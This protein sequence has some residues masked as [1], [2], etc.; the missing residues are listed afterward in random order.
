MRP[1]SAANSLVILP[2][3]PGAITWDGSTLVFTPNLPWPS[4]AEITVQFEGGAR[5]A[6][7]PG[8][9]LMQTFTWRFQ[10]SQ[11]TLA[12]LWPSAG[13]ADLYTL[14]PSS[15]YTRRLTNLGGV[16]GYSLSPDGSTFF[17]S[18]DDGSGV[19]WIYRLERAQIDLASEE[20]PVLTPLIECPRATCYRAQLSPDGQWLVYER[21]PLSVSGTSAANAVWL[22]SMSEKSSRLL[23][24][25]GQV[26]HSPV[27]SAASMLAYYSTRDQAFI[28]YDPSDNTQRLLPN[29]T[30][31]PGVWSPDGRTFVAQEVFIEAINLLEPQTSS[32]LIRYDIPEDSTDDSLIVQTD[33]S[34]AFDQEDLYPAFSPD[35]ARLAFARRYL[36]P[37]RWTPGRQLWIMNADGSAARPLSNAPAYNHYH[38]AWNAAG[39]QIAYVRFD[40]TS[41]TQ[42][43]ELWLIQSDGSNPIQLVIGGYAPLWAP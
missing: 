18:A 10:I 42:P 3:L 15:G 7:F 12:Y 14:D 2:E 43:P 39:D 37:T 25:T 36:D 13:S 1:E 27:W 19:S 24:P 29:Q 38:F 8:F 23:S 33:L 35:G 17:I 26:S 28:V 6:G 22:Y 30:G 16:L 4:G 41:L 34:A 32:H 21:I 11:T 40:P 31:E 5:A 9:P 20:L